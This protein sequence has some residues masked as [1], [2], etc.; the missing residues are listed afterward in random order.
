MRILNLEL[1]SHIVFRTIIIT[2]INIWTFMS[3]TIIKKRI[4][5]IISL[6]CLKLDREEFGLRNLLFRAII[7]VGCDDFLCLAC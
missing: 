5:D 4:T 3:K 2:V 1:S 6:M 7:K